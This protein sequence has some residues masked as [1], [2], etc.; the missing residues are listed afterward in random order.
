M[1]AGQPEGCPD[2]TMICSERLGRLSVGGSDAAD[3]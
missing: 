2:R 3:S 1:S